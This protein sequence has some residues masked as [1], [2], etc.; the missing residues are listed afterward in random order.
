MLRLLSM[1]QYYYDPIAAYNQARLFNLIFW[2]IFIVVW[3]V[4]GIACA[5]YVYK[6]ARRSRMN[7]TAWAVIC[8]L[9]NLIGLVIYLL[10]KNSKG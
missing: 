2:I 4:V 7:A 5:V 6:D 8:V 3:L 10:I 9:L 1:L